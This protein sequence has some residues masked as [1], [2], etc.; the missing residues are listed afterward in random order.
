LLG[1]SPDFGAIEV[2]ALLDMARMRR[3]DGIGQAQK[4]LG[5]NPGDFEAIEVLPTYFA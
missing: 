2:A 5:Y 4:T 1:R 3:N